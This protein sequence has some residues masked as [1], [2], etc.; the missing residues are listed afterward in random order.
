MNKGLA[1]DRKVLVKHAKR[2]KVLSSVIE[3]RERVISTT[4]TFSTTEWLSSIIGCYSSKDSN[5]GP[6]LCVIATVILKRG[7]KDEE[8]GSNPFGP[9]AKTFPRGEILPEGSRASRRRV[10]R[11]FLGNAA[12]KTRDSTDVIHNG[13]RSSPPGIRFFFLHGT[14]ERRIL[15]MW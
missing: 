14:M 13:P 9:A 10:E 6:S 1:T 4:D 7:G 15:K 11:I 8:A 3:E 5:G 2:I 12:N